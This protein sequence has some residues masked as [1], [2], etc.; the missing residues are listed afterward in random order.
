M[1]LFRQQA[2]DYQRRR[3]WGDVILTQSLSSWAIVALV[4]AIVVAAGAFLWSQDYKRKESVAGY[5]VPDTGLIRY[6]A[7]Q[8]GSLATLD[9]AAG[10]RVE[11]GQVLGFIRSDKKTETGLS[12]SDTLIASVRRDIETLNQLIQTSAARSDAERSLLQQREK[13]QRRQIDI[14]RKELMLLNDRIALAKEGV[15]A[16][17][18]LAAKGNAP[19]ALINDRKQSLLSLQQ[20]QIETE[21]QLVAAQESLVLLTNELE[22]FDLKR[23]EEQ[24]SLASRRE[25]LIQQLETTRL[26]AGYSLVAPADGVVDSL[27]VSAGQA[28]RPGQAILTVR[29]EGSVLQAHLLV[30]SR[31]A[32]LIKVGQDARIQYDAFPYQR[33]GIFTGTVAEIADGI[34]APGEVPVPIPMEESFYLVTLDLDNQTV[35]VSGS[36]VALKSGMQLTADVTLES[37]SLLAWVLD[38]ILSLK[39]RL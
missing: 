15:E 18:D 33:F 7:D 37:R 39:G 1:T 16:I 34:A 24:L 14:T 25:A 36:A 17:N 19:R 13:S 27:F 23:Q 4:F 11:R 6:Y 32:G 35:P 8:S 38:P 12:S 3:L 30:P 9:I 29:P 22:T 28:L 5:L 10:T 20:S 21:R 31:S 2:L 26:T